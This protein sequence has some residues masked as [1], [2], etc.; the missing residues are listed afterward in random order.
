MID[1]LHLEIQIQT[2]IRMLYMSAEKNS[3]ACKLAD[4][5]S[6][7]AALNKTT[8]GTSSRRNLFECHLLL[9]IGKCYPVNIKYATSVLCHTRQYINAAHK[10]YN[11]SYSINIIG[12]DVVTQMLRNSM[13]TGCSPE[14]EVNSRST[15]VQLVQ[16]S[17]LLRRSRH[18]WSHVSLVQGDTTAARRRL[19]LQSNDIGVESYRIT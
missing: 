10:Q 12:Y 13:F 16:N 3:F 11:V 1:S 4:S 6:S 9:D 15:C 14:E 5:W 7:R 8:L 19:I 18:I 2:Y 17:K